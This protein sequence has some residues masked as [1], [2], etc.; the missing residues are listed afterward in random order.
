MKHILNKAVLFFSIFLVSI[1]LGAPFAQAQNV[2]KNSDKSG[3]PKYVVDPYWPKALPNDWILG[4]VSGIAVDSKNHI[5]IIQR[6]RTL[7]PDELAA[8]FNPPNS[9]CC[10]PAPAVIEFDEKGNVLQAWG[11]PGEGYDWPKNEHGIYVDPKGNVWIA[12]NDKEDRMILKFT[13]QGKFLMQI[14]T[15][16]IEQSSNDTK[17]LGRP[18]HMN[19]DSAANEIYVADGYQN[20]RVIV[21][22]ADSGEYKR[23]WGAF[24]NKPI[25]GA[26]P[27]YNPKAEQFGNP[28]HC[29]RIMNDG[30]V[31]VCDRSENRIQVFNKDGQFMRQIVLDT[32]TRGSSNGSSGSV[33]D[34]VPSPDQ[35]QK[36]LFVADGTNNEV[37]IILR[38]TGEKVGS[39]GRSGRMAGD[40]HWVHNIAIDSYGNIFT[41][42]V[43]N[44]KRVQKF[45]LM[46]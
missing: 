46:K 14:G 24:G 43:D 44:A 3:V 12:G 36:Y 37:K 26:Y 29:V 32:Q 40:F 10:K 45:V 34:F 35:N 18:A 8:T 39:F 5:W 1:T 31:Y 6:P 22:D 2:N 11:G 13:N 21:F 33:W 4:Q 41:S 17:N 28:V 16:G 9:R 15:P 38:E 20:R 7:T 27:S 42:E 30:L 19:L 23:H 25:D